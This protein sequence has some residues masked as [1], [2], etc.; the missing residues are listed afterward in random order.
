MVYILIPVFNE[1]E[2]IPALAENL[3]TFFK[4]FD[5][6]PHFIFVDDFSN[7]NTIKSINN[8]FKESNYTIIEKSSNIGPGDS[9]NRGFNWIIENSS[10]E[11]LVNDIVI[12]MEADNTCDLKIL[13]IMV[14]LAEQNIDLVLASVYAQGG[15]FE[16]TGFIRVVL[17]FC[18]NLFFRS[19]FNLKI[20]TLSS[21][22]RVYRLELISK[23]KD[24]NKEII[25][26]RG[27][28]SM[29]EVLIKAIKLDATVVEVP[30]RLKSL[31]RKGKSKMKLMKTTLSY[32]RFL[33][34]SQR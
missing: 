13:P 24:N 34:K 19:F 4:G 25:N 10:K 32:I 30:M 8:F 9:F 20:L 14:S 2:N 23:I 18:A 16:K 15:G 3:L 31:N 21:F 17:S 33:F 7:D 6:K 29:L 27:F 28:I 26:E 11:N 1:E 22:Y 5:P 12:T